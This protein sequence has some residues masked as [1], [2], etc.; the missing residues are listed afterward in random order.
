MNKKIFMNFSI[1]DLIV[2][3][4]PV[5]FLAILILIFAYRHLDPAPPS[6]LSISTDGDQSDFMEFAKKYQEILKAD[7]VTLEVRASGGPLD[8]LRR[9]QDENSGISA[10]FVQDG[11]GS[12]TE[13]P[14][15]SSLGSIYYEPLWVFYRGKMVLN[16]LSQLEGKKIAIGKIGRGTHVIASRLLGLSGVDFKRTK[17]IDSDS[18]AS[19]AAL[20][21][22]EIDAAILMLSPDSPVVHELAMDP[23]IHLMDVLQAEGVT[24]LD[25]SFHH[26]LLPRGALDLKNDIPSTEVNLLA[27]TATLLVRDDLHPALAYLL[28]KA[29]SQV[30]SGPGIFE[31]RGEFPTN[32]DD[33]FPL[34]EDAIQFYKS[35]GPFWQRYLPYWL[36]A[37]LDRF[38]LLVIPVLAVVLPLVRAIPRI[39]HW[40]IRSRIYQR[41][42]ELKFLETQVKPTLTDAE[43]MDF[44]RKLEAIEDRVNNMKVPPNF[45]EYVYS[46]RGHIQFV[47]ER[48]AKR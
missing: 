30:H 40:R 21:K 5:G 14:D 22:G 31:K 2:A 3:I 1:K 28:L 16:H 33:Q 13:Q 35:G 47:R 48:L 44:Y 25:A 32:K 43:Y 18:V 41:Y 9:L 8:N 36:A 46:L 12:T 24:R 19:A 4:G 26:L 34:S 7:G 29:A 23:D 45:T 37:W 10:A 15:V 17:I 6:H 11:L 20:K 38:V 27:S 42:G 39:Y